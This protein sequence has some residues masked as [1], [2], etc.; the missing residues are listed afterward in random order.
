MKFVVEHMEPELF[1]WCIIEYAHISEM[2]GK[3][4]ILFTN[5]EKADFSK[6]AEYGEV[7]G[8]KVADL[9]LSKACILDPYAKQ[10]L[11]SKDNAEFDYLVLGGILG[12]NPAEK[13]TAKLTSVL[14]YPARNLGEKQ[15]ST[16]TA[17]YVAK[18][19]LEGKAMSDFHFVEEV[20]VQI[21][22]FE[23]VIL[24][25]PYVIENSKIVMSEELVEH[26]R[27]RKEF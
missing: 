8:K 25:F 4:N 1:E 20:E 7:T 19:I 5:I 10:T 27:K 12:N 6:L 22:D 2:V 9:G 13:R 14:S 21:D 11:T 16:D 17:A 24:P 18:R 3:K 15:L 26:L 23:S